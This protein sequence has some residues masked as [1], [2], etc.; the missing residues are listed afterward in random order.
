MSS[1]SSSLLKLLYCAFCGSTDSLLK[2][3]ENVFIIF[4][5]DWTWESSA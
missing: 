2:K 5:L 4:I 3:G 1:T